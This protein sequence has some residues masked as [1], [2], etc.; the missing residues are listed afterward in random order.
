VKILGSG[1]GQTQTIITTSPSTISLQKALPENATLKCTECSFVSKQASQFVKHLLV[2]K[3]QHNLGPKVQVRI[4]RKRTIREIHI[5]INSLLGLN[6][7]MINLH[8]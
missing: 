5:Q 6:K 4:R 8:C 2:H 1:L 7:V 3:T